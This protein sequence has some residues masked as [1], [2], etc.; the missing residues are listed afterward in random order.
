MSI[1]DVIVHLNSRIRGFCNYFKWSNAHRA[2]A[3]L[4]HRIFW[5]L[6]NYV[7]RKHQRRHGSHWLKYEYWRPKKRGNW[8]FSFKGIDLVQPSGFTVQWWKR[9]AVRIHTSPHDP[10]ERQYWKQRAAKETWCNPLEA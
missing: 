10:D 6:W 9:P 4:G 7:E 1:Q 3:Y 2:F 5:M 8:I